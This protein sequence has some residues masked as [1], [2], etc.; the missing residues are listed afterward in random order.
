MNKIAI[1]FIRIKDFFREL[2]CIHEWSD[3]FYA[4]FDH[5]KIEIIKNY[6]ELPLI[7][8]YPNMLN[9]VFMNI[10]INA[11]QSIKE[12][13]I[14]TIT[15]D[16]S[17]NTLTVKIK[18][19]GKGISKENLDKIFTAGYTTK[20]VGVGTGLGLAISEKIIQKHN[21]KIKVTSEL[22]RGSEFTI[23]IPG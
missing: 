18:D 5:N 2:F 15:T 10:L 7:K 1:V 3:N 13:G 12:K 6:S 21:G 23:T 9:Q 20:G 8:C 22:G 11:C 14:I 4:S 16:Y 17:N 19:N